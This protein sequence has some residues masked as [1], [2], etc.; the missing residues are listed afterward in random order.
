MKKLNMFLLIFIFLIGISSAYTISNYD[1]SSSSISSSVYYSTGL[2]YEDC[3]DGNDFI[4]QIEPGSCEP[5]LV[6]S[7]LLEEEPVTVYCKLIATQVNPFI[8]VESISSISVTGDYSSDVQS[9][10]YFPSESALGYWTDNSL[11]SLVLND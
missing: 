11:D 7:D 8:D 9:V 2:D 1:Y 5:T 4:V 10:G 3:Q 6:T